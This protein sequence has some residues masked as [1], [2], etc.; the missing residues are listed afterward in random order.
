MDGRDAAFEAFV[1]A[2]SA[3]L[4]RTAYLLTGDAAAADDLLQDALLKVYLAWPRIRDLGAVEEYTRRAMT[5]THVSV[6]R[7]L[8]RRETS[9]ADPAALTT[10]ARL[11]D[12]HKP[13][14][15]PETTTIEHRDELWRA[16]TTLGP[17][18]RA[19]VVLRFYE[20]LAEADIA[21][22][23]GCSVGTVKSQLAR[24][25]AGLNRRIGAA[26]ALDAITA[27]TGLD[28]RL[29]DPR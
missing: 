27:P 19:V 3:A 26:R 10:G 28:L 13:D 1:A 29:E 25:L 22:V 23:L 24:G 2:R 11:R 17:R 5:R 9:V 4:R 20:D 16:L 12:P 6:W 21:R 18:Q 14:G 7:R 15:T 8:G